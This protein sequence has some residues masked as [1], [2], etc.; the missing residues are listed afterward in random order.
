[1]FSLIA[2]IAISLLIVTPAFSGGWSGK[3]VDLRNG[4]PIPDVEVCAGTTGR[5]DYGECKYSE[6][7]GSFVVNY[8]GEIPE[9]AVLYVNPMGNYKDLYLPTELC[10]PPGN[11]LVKLVPAKIFIKGR[12]VDK[13]TKAPLNGVNI[14]YS[15]VGSATT[16]ASGLFQY[17]RKGLDV[18]GLSS[19]GLY[20]HGYEG[21]PQS[22]L[23]PY[24]EP[25]QYLPQRFSVSFSGYKGLEVKNIPVKSSSE[26]TIFTYC[27][28]EL[29]PS[30][31]SEESTYSCRVIENGNIP[32]GP[33]IAVKDTDGDGVIDAWDKC[34]DTPPGT[35]VFSDGCPAET[36]PEGCFAT[37]DLKTLTLDIPC[38]SLNGEI[39]RVKMS[40]INTN[41][42][43]FKLQ[44]IKEAQP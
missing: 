32:E 2:S 5:V 39:Y 14:L 37:F 43:L 10:G 42:I 3:I 12:V 7:D 4:K 16:D 29:A 13:I 18:Y 9:D 6:S 1:M 34:P 30:D 15:S 11:V 19:G 25:E 23:C 26:D 38:L 21:V 31:S 40:L 41:P 8:P 17:E 33:E 22:Y 36:T 44:S 35:P 28:I 24:A 27:L 20:P